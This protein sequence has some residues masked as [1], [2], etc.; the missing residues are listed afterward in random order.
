M[1]CKPGLALPKQCL[2][3]LEVD[4]ISHHHHPWR[5]SQERQLE[6]GTGQL[7]EFII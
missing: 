5:V 6:A 4:D 7:E 3:C 2:K 1:L